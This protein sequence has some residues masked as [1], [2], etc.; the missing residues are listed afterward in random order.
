MADCSQLFFWNGFALFIGNLTD[1]SNHKHHAIQLCL[2]LDKP[3]L[4]THDSGSGWY[5]SA[6]IASDISH[7]FQGADG[8]HILILI[9]PESA[10]GCHLTHALLAKSP[11]ADLESLLA[12]L[13]VNQRIPLQGQGQLSCDMAS[14]IRAHILSALGFVKSEPAAMDPRIQIA[15]ILMRE[16]ETKKISARAMAAALAISETRLIHLFKENVGIPIR[17]Y[18]LWL[19]LIEAVKHLLSGISLTEAAHVAGFA[20]SA[21]LSRTFR[22]MFG[23]SPSDIF[24]NDRFIQAISCPS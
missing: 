18:L 6:I 15:L 10:E 2:A 22:R 16:M 21:H 9:E 24:K 1:N 19:R 7:Q 12:P 3:F 13:Q 8:R 5:R 4:L 14:E 11:L 23:F 17:P 20:D